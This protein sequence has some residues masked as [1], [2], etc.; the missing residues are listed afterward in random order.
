MG[1]RRRS[2]EARARR[3][4]DGLLH[5]PLVVDDELRRLPPADPGELEDRAPSLRRRRDAQ[6]RD[7]QPAGRARRH[8]PARPPR[9]G[10][11]Q[12]IAPVR[13]SLGAGAVLDQHQPRAHLHPA[14]ADRRRRA[15][16]RQAFA[17]HYPAHRAQDRDQDLQRLPHLGS[18]TTTTRSWRSC[19]CTGPTSS[20]SSGYNAWVGEEQRH[21]GGAGH[22]MGRAAGGDRQLPAPLRLSRTGSRQHQKREPRLPDSARATHAGAARLPRSCAASTCTSPKGSGGMRVYDVASIANKGVSQRI[23]TAPFSPLGP[24]HAHR[25]RRT[26][27]ASRCPP[28]SRSTRCATTGE[29]MRG[30]ATRS[31]RSTRSTATP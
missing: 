22:R 15:S 8:V 28:T 26:P 6:L 3:R 5:L 29:L 14:A 2:G 27:P 31:S 11:G 7:L 9:P 17:P 10:Q 20:T 18:T 24:G 25:A 19:C 30:D 21:R 1:S 4:Q 13:S 16:R 23:I 12:R